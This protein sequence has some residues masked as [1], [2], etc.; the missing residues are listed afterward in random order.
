MIKLLTG[1]GKSLNEVVNLVNEAF[2]TNISRT[3][4]DKRIHH[5]GLERPNKIVKVDKEVRKQQRDNM[6]YEMYANMIDKLKELKR[7]QGWYRQNDDKLITNQDIMRQLGLGPDKFKEICEMYDIPERMI[8]S[9]NR[10][11]LYYNVTVPDGRNVIEVD[12]EL[13]V[14][15]TSMQEKHLDH[16]YDFIMER[17][18]KDMRVER[19]AI[20][21]VGG[22]FVDYK[23]EKDERARMFINPIKIKVDLYFPDYNIA[24]YHALED[25]KITK[26]GYYSGIP[27][28]YS[29]YMKRCKNKIQ[30]V[31]YMAM[32]TVTDGMW[33][34]GA[35][36]DNI[37][38]RLSVG[39]TYRWGRD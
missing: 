4:I 1:Q 27:N 13:V 35:A 2:N 32:Y 36:A 18:P 16:I 17:K 6:K 33:S 34:L 23:T 24:F 20:I 3:V 14:D 19:D 37:L 11:D 30:L 5:L 9:G 21:E 29:S 10:P 8:C 26:Q 28:C 12:G 31:P 22:S 7:Q 39:D 25:D 15:C 38:K